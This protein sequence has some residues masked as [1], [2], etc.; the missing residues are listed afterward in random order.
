MLAIRVNPCSSISHHNN[1][2]LPLFC[3]GQILAS[4]SI[5]D[6]DQ[7]MI[8]ELLP[9]LI[10]QHRKWNLASIHFQKKMTIFVL[11]SQEEALAINRELNR[12][13]GCVVP[14][15]VRGNEQLH[16]N[17]DVYLPCD[18]NLEF[19]NSAGPL[20]LDPIRFTQRV[21]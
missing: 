13:A 2:G 7:E 1:G 5:T 18:V 15:P 20:L 9:V 8:C 19:L 16:A 12:S 4:Q 10:R 21:P 14:A 17:R 6:L 11:L 3:L